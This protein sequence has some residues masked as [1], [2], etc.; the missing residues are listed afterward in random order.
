MYSAKAP[1]SPSEMDQTGN[2]DEYSG[3]VKAAKIHIFKS[4]PSKKEPVGITTTSPRSLSRGTSSEGSKLLQLLKSKTVKSEQSPKQMDRRNSDQSLTWVRENF[5]SVSEDS[6]AQSRETE[7]NGSTK[8]FHDR[9]SRWILLP[10][11]YKVP[12]SK[13]NPR[14]VSADMSAQTNGQEARDTESSNPV[15]NAIEFPLPTAA[16]RVLDPPPADPE[17]SLEIPL[18][19]S[20]S[21]TTNNT[22]TVPP[23]EL[24]SKPSSAPIVQEMISQSPAKNVV[25][26]TYPLAL[27]NVLHRSPVEQGSIFPSGPKA[28]RFSDG[29]PTKDGSTALEMEQTHQRNVLPTKSDQLAPEEKST[30]SQVVEEVATPLNPEI[31]S[32]AGSTSN[33]HPDS[34]PK[35][36]SVPSNLISSNSHE[37]PAEVETSEQN[38]Q[39]QSGVDK[40]ASQQSTARPGSENAGNQESERSAAVV[41]KTSVSK[42]VSSEERAGSLNTVEAKKAPHESLASSRPSSSS[43]GENETG[44]PTIQSQAPATPPLNNAPGTKSHAKGSTEQR[45]NLVLRKDKVPPKSRLST[46]PSLEAIR[47]V[48]IPTSRM[49]SGKGYRPQVGTVFDVFLKEKSI[50]S[51]QPTP[52]RPSDLGDQLLVGDKSELFEALHTQTPNASVVGAKNNEK[53]N[54]PHDWNTGFSWSTKITMG[55]GLTARNDTSGN[56]SFVTRSAPPIIGLDAREDKLSGLNRSYPE[57]YP[58]QGPAN[59]TQP[60]ISLG[61]PSMSVERM[62]ENGGAWTNGDKGRDVRQLRETLVKSQVR[63]NP[64][65]QASSRHTRRESSEVDEGKEKDLFRQAGLISP[66]SRSAESSSSTPFLRTFLTTNVVD[67]TDQ[68][69]SQNSQATKEK[70]KDAFGLVDSAPTGI[71]ADQSLPSTPPPKVPESTNKSSSRMEQVVTNQ[72]GGH[73]DFQNALSQSPKSLTER[74]RLGSNEFTDDRPL[75]KSGLS[76]AV[77][78]YANGKKNVVI[79]DPVNGSRPANNFKAF[80]SLPGR[81]HTVGSKASSLQTG[82]I[83]RSINDQQMSGPMPQALAKDLRVKL[84]S[85]KDVPSK[86][87][88]L[89]DMKP[90][91]EVVIGIAIPEMIESGMAQGSFST[92]AIN[93][94]EK[95]AAPLLQRASDPQLGNVSSGD[96]GDASS[97]SSE[98]SAKETDRSALRS[99]KDRAKFPAIDSE[100]GK[101]FLEAP[102]PHLYSDPLLASIERSV[103]AASSKANATPPTA[104]FTSLKNPEEDRKKT[105]RLV[106]R[107]IGAELAIAK[108]LNKKMLVNLILSG[109]IACSPL[110]SGRLVTSSNDICNNNNYEESPALYLQHLSKRARLESSAFDR[111]QVPVLDNQV[112]VLDKLTVESIRKGLRDACFYI[113]KGEVDPKDLNKQNIVHERVMKLKDFLLRLGCLTS[114]A[115]SPYVNIIVLIN[116]LVGLKSDVRSFEYSGT[117]IWNYEYAVRLF[118]LV[119]RTGDFFTNNEGSYSLGASP[120]RRL[121]E[122][123]ERRSDASKVMTELPHKVTDPKDTDLKMALT[124][125]EERANQILARL[126]ETKARDGGCRLFVESVSSSDIDVIGDGL[127]NL[128]DVRPRTS[129]KLTDS[130]SQISNNVT[131]LKLRTLASETI[132][133]QFKIASLHGRL[134]AK[135]K[136]IVRLTSRLTE[137]QRRIEKWRLVSSCLAPKVLEGIAET[138]AESNRCFI[139]QENESQNEMQLVTPSNTDSQSGVLDESVVENIHVIKNALHARPGSGG[140]GDQV[141]AKGQAGLGSARDQLAQASQ[142]DDLFFSRII[143]LSKRVTNTISSEQELRKLVDDLKSERKTLEETLMTTMQERESE[144]KEAD[145]K[146]VASQQIIDEQRQAILSLKEQVKGEKVKRKALGA[147]LNALISYQNSG[148]EEDSGKE[149]PE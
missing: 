133:D 27:K 112:T 23:A 78:Q 41:T 121:T 98:H 36:A 47:R 79:R 99:R 80:S 40:P 83:T 1:S 139:P 92:H 24:H 57:R 54:E 51:L 17:R 119:S 55:N 6:T 84:R 14:R 12:S 31:K 122:R 7:K 103:N 148:E 107:R 48:S 58:V 62:L 126:E 30:H 96:S 10:S 3:P 146:L 16:S 97:D 114:D 93:P 102:S 134:S 115:K 11:P 108:G 110:K 130:R 53:R 61:T 56:A 66:S 64:N 67:G 75:K 19:A 46:S 125:E 69:A 63:E 44:K 33:N 81:L 131:D 39:I 13:A 85:V 73:L 35:E 37:G 143:A 5:E 60:S 123:V 149:G 116:D 76:Q 50:S 52:V 145:Q 25:T 74:K 72:L 91:K 113:D 32:S 120:N 135:D 140:H 117:Q 142:S 21:T 26:K 147:S 22:N 77:P 65:V 118:E 124:L 109:V 4:T 100:L 87:S 18:M 95:I 136:E 8:S 137:E 138:E 105:E 101:S 49:S 89:P 9:V 20:G 88:L 90:L 111:A 86:K 70:S 28:M 45:R 128:T 144:K 2:G 38:P 59:M 43:K 94:S 71:H 34:E 82:Q 141:S 129:D 106:A 132:K 15:S 127:D 68:F 104:T 42:T 29:T